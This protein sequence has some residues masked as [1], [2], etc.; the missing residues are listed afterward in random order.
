MVTGN[1]DGGTSPADVYGHIFPALARANDHVDQMLAVF[2]Q[3]RLDEEMP[4]V[5]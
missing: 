5:M 1:Q 3:L 4:G 2:R